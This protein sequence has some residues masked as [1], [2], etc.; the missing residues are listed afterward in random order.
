MVS[1]HLSKGVRAEIV[2]GQK[3]TTIQRHP[4]VAQN[5]E[6]VAPGVGEYPPYEMARLQ[7][8]PARHKYQP[9]VHGD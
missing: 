4:V 9:V 7:S 3:Q 5:A 2:S 8:M 6:E 1:L